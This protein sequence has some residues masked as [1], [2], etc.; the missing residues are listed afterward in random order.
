MSFC[1]CFFQK[2]SCRPTEKIDS[3]AQ[4]M[5][6]ANP[7]SGSLLPMSPLFQEGS[8]ITLNSDTEIRL[9]PGYLYLINYLFTATPEVD[10]Y[11]Q[12]TPQINDALSLLYSSFAPSGSGSRDTSTAGSFTTNAALAEAAILNFRLTYPGT[13]RNIDISGAVSVTPL[14]KL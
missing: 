2:R 13:V 7:A 10:G 11:M 5:V 1:N 14:P 3:Y 12:I 6:R 4:Y 8:L 9:A